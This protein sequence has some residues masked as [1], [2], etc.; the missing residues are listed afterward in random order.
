M[1]E[2]E[3]GIAG[4][5]PIGDRDRPSAVGGLLLG[6]ESIPKQVHMA[7]NVLRDPRNYLQR[8]PGAEEQDHMLVGCL[9]PLSQTPPKVQD[10]WF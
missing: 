9:L 5:K 1:S 8:A 6:T 2:K 7:R 10:A 4:G 3:N